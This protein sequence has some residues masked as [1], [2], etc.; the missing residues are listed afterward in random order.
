M[1]RSLICQ[2]QCKLIKRSGIT[3]NI[4]VPRSVIKRIEIKWTT[5]RLLVAVKKMV[6]IIQKEL[7]L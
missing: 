2:S 1:D 4:N 7:K 5:M 6:I 3:I